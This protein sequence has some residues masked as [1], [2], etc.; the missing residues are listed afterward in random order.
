[1]KTFK[2]ENTADVG[3][4]IGMILLLGFLL[5]W[6]L[7]GLWEAVRGFLVELVVLGATF[8]IAR[9][10]LPWEDAPRERIVNPG[11]ELLLSAVGFIVFIIVWPLLL[12]VGDVESLYINLMFAFASLLVFSA[13]VMVPFR[14]SLKAWGL[15]LPTSRELLV[16]LAVA[17]VGIGLSL[18]FGSLLPASEVPEYVNPARPLLPGALLWSF[19]ESASQNNFAML[20]VVGVF[21]LSVV[22]QELFFRVYLQARLAQYLPGRWALF[23]QAALYFVACMLPLY[24]LVGGLPPAFMLTQA[25][26]LSNAVLAGYFWRKT[27]S[28]PL[29]VLLHLLAF[30][31]WGL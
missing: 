11:R 13:A 8:Y 3:I 12:P 24:L 5:A 29:L 15:R 14:Y 30:V 27:G 18:L 19:W 16:L 20:M 22:G 7:L 23:A 10:Y 28:L 4:L 31:R 1:M 26:V 21:V 17:V 2:L 6:P 9:Q 25:A